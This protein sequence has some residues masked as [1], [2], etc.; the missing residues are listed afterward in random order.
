MVMMTWTVLLT[1]EREALSGSEKQRYLD[2]GTAEMKG[3][4][5]MCFRQMWNGLLN[6]INYM[7]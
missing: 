5:E 3:E 1:L 2:L 4:P 7:S 6:I